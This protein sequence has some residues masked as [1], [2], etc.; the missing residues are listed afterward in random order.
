MTLDI[1]HEPVVPHH[2]PGEVYIFGINLIS[3]LEK[4][5]NE[6]FHISSGT[7]YSKVP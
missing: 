5:A 7:N 3:T 2:L 4:M 6:I 1:F